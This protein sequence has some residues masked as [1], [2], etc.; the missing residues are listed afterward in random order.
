MNICSV[1]LAAGQGTRMKSTLPK[2]LHPLLGRPM[3]Q[4][5]LDTAAAV[6]REQ[7]VVI[8]GHGASQIEQAFNG[9]ARFV[10]QAPQLGTGHAVQQAE[11]LLRD[12]ADYVVVTYAD[13][14]LLTTETLERVVQAQK[15]NS[16]PMTMLTTMVEDRVDLVAL[17][18][19]LTEACNGDR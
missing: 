7:P 17:Y 19:A 9:K 5:S 10:L 11:S 13:M 14:P 8:I 6:S 16:G 12:E 15:A 2:V 18:V 3:L 1:I 4:Y